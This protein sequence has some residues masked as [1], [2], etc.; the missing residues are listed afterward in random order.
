MAGVGAEKPLVRIVVAGHVDHGKSTLIGRIRHEICALAD[1]AALDGSVD[2]N[3]AFAM[4]QLQEERERMMTIDTAQTFV[5]TPS[6][7]IVF[8][9]VPGHQELIQ[10]MLTG[11]TRADH[12][13]LVL[14]ADEGVQVQTRRHALLLSLIGMTGVVVVAN[15][16]DAV[17]FAEPTFRA[18]EGAI[19][20]HLAELGIDALSVIPVV[21]LDGANVLQRSPVMPWYDGPALMELLADLEPRTSEGGAAR[22]PVQDVY[23]HDGERIVVGRVAAGRIAEGDALVT[24]PTGGAVALHEIRRF[25]ADHLPAG[26]GESIGLILDGAPPRRGDV[27]APADDL[28][29]VAAT[30]SGR[31]F[32]LAEQPL[33]VGEELTLRCAT[34]V[35]PVRVATITERIETVELEALPEDGRLATME[36]ATVVLT[37]DRPLVFERFAVVPGL[38]RFVLERAGLPVGF[39][40][41][42]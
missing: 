20:G 13:V 30:V 14:A 6:T 35:A 40:I 36:L 2:G 32:W 9:D 17:G 7:R 31:V 12:A 1:A 39:G 34:Q 25:P 4:D 37:A 26:V 8:I 23:E 11:A 24:L 41:I 5:H 16:M 27:L 38:G 42:A 29:K 3:W 22:V 19:V 33:V 10:N 18:L 15:K 21:A 28:P